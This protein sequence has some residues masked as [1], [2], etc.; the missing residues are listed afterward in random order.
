MS[1]GKKDFLSIADHTTE[2]LRKILELAKE[3]KP[4]AR[5]HKLPH[6]HPNRTMACVFAKDGIHPINNKQIISK[7][8]SR[9][10]YRALRGEGLY[11]YSGKWDTDV[12]SISAKS[13]VGG[14][15]FI[16][17]KGIGGIG[18]VSPKLDKIGNSVRGIQA[19]T[20]LAKKFHP[21]LYHNKQCSF[22][23]KFTKRKRTYSKKKKTVRNI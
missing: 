23:K 14:G 10:I 5:D 4:L 15:I 6:S 11:E 13:G 7:E 1:L 16:I 21:V 19:G 17:L 2:D 12:G 18:I 22:N 9:Y 3:Q 20:M 8:A